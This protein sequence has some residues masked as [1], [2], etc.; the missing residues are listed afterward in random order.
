M[1]QVNILMA[2]FAIQRI[3]DR[4]DVAM[5]ELD[6][7]VANFEDMVSPA[8]GTVVVADCLCRRLH[9]CRRSLRRH[10]IKSLTKETNREGFQS[11][12][13]TWSAD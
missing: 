9:N 8:A 13:T 6:V 1:W 5:T 11:Y 7:V 12:Y 2:E 10:K 3:G 4:I